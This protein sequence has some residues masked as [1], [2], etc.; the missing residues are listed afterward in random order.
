MKRKEMKA[1][2]R[3]QIEGKIGPLF[4]VSF[5]GN[6][7]AS[8][9]SGFPIVGVILSFILTSAIS[10]G[11]IYIHFRVAADPSYRP[12][13]GDLFNGFN[14]FWP[15]LKVMLLSSLFTFLWSLLFVV[16]GI[17]KALA[18]S[19]APY[20]IAENPN[21]PA[22][23]A[24]RQSERMMKGRKTEYFVLNL[25]FIG[26]ALLAIPTLGLLYIWLEP[27]MQMTM[28]NFYSDLKSSQGYF[29]PF[30]TTPPPPP[31]PFGEQF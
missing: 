4:L 27:Y 31:P 3:L 28:I 8:A 21:M 16:P 30:G 10:L 17:V 2:A 9:G 15:F 13:V 18:Y 24:L 23:E 26:W 6:I 14:N 19:Q 20:I 25:S 22:M 29:D 12:R 11:L 5:V 7:I 1:L